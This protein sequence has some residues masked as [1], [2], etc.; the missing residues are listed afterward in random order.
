VTRVLV[1]AAS[2]VVRAGLEAVVRGSES[3]EL[4]GSAGASGVT[5]LAE[6]IPHLQPDVVLVELEPHDDEQMEALAALA[7]RGAGGRTGYPL[8]ARGAPAVV[9]LAND[10]EGRWATEALRA[11]ARGILSRDASA[12][13]I[14]AAVEAAAAGL[15]ALQPSEVDA[16]LPGPLPEPS[17]GRPEAPNSHPSSTAAPGETLT[18]RETEIL[19]MLAEGL[20]NKEIAWRL[21]ISEHTVK[22]HVAS[23]LSKLDASSRTE[24]VT[25][26]LRQGLI[27]L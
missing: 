21:K 16:L 3:L 2:G 27:M 8:E 10:G 20:G 11:G 25:L 14:I 19:G 9:V 26:G 18:R 7:G 24:A 6:E 4:A 17:P 5:S 23:I 15:V 12:A 1:V 22:F 13:E